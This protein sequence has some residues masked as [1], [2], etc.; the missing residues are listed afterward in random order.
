MIVSGVWLGYEKTIEPLTVLLFS[1]AGFIA[2]DTWPEKVLN[3]H[4]KKLFNHFL[5]DLPY[6]GSIKFINENNFAGFSFN[7]KNLDQLNKFVHKWNS[8]EYHF[9]HKGLENKRKNLYEKI[10]SYLHCLGINTWTLKGN[11]EWSTVPPEWEEEQ[12][13]RFN[14]IVNTLHNSAEEIVK[15]YRELVDL[16][17][18]K[19]LKKYST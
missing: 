9:I 6:E 3:P 8:P 2:T 18:K 7:R 11:I 16:G 1:L 12:P 10:N 15:I 19:N 17:V 13:D 5:N 14:K 4:D